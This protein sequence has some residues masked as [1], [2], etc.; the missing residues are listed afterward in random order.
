MNVSFNSVS[1]YAHI[2]WGYIFVTAPAL[3]F[4]PKVLWWTLG[5][6][7]LG[8]AIKEIWDSNGLETKE[9]AGNSWEDFGFWCIGNFTA[10]ISIEVGMRLG[11]LR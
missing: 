6:C 11:H 2:G 3:L 9:V 10:V 1:Q 5:V 4:G 7:I 8:E